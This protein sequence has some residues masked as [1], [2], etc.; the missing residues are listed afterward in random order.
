MHLEIDSQ[1]NLCFGALSP[2]C[3]ES[4]LQ[5]PG[6]L[7]SEDPRVRAR[8]LPETFS[9]PEEEKQWRRFGADELEHLFAS[10]V[11]L[12]EQDLRGIE[13]DGE[14]SFRL[15][16]EGRHR[17]AWLSGLNAARLTLFILHELAEDD[18]DKEPGLIGDLDKDMA[19]LRI[20]LLAYMQEMMIEGGG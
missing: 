7:R 18:I 8:L 4:L 11:E 17:S 9:D 20:H 6:L 10:R 5:I 1:G 14:S 19:L 16:I 3:A 13:Q 12:I 15:A 2:I